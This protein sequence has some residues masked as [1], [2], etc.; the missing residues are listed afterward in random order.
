MSGWTRAF[1]LVA[2]TVVGMGAAGCMNCPKPGAV[3]QKPAPVRA[4][5]PVSIDLS[6]ESDVN[7]VKTQHVFVATVRDANGNPVSGADVEWI[8]SRSGA[9]SVGDIVDV[10]GGKKI[11]NTYA[12]STTG[13]SS[14]TITRGNDNPADDVQVGPGQTW[15]VITSTEEGQSKMVA[16]A[17]SIR[18]WD[19][20]KAFA[21]KNWMDMSWES[22]AD[23]TN[24]VGTPHTFAFRVFKFSDGSPISDV[25]V[26]W[27]IIS[28]PDGT[29]T[30]GGRTAATK[31]DGSGWAKVDLNQ[32]TPM[33]GT[34]EVQI[35]VV[36]P[37][38]KDECRCWP[39]SM[40]G[41]WTVRKTWVA[42]SIA[43]VKNGPA[44]ETVGHSF[45]YD[46][47]VT[48]TSDLEL[49]DVV[50]TDPLNSAIA[51]ESSNPSADVS[52]STLTWRLGSMAGG[53][54]RSI[55]VMVHGTQTGGPYENCAMV[56]AEGGLN[57]RSCV[58]T[59]FAAPA[60]T[61]DKSGP[62][63]A[64]VCD[65]ITYTITVSNTG[66]GEATNVRVVDTMPSGVTTNDQTE[67]NCG[68]I[69]AHE[70]HTFTITARS[71][72]TGSKTNRVTVTGDGGLTAS[73]SVTTNFT[74][75]VLSI[76]KTAPADRKSGR[77]LPY[78]IT[79][80]NVGS[81]DARGVVVTDAIPN[82]ASFTSASD[83]GMCPSGTQVVWNLGTLAPGQSRTVTLQLVATMVQGTIRNTVMAH[84]DC[85]DEVSASAETR[86][87]G[88]AAILLETMD[89]DDP[90][91]IGGTETYV[92]EVTNQG[93]IPDTNV[94]IECTLPPEE[95]FVSAQGPNGT[96][97]TS[98]GKTV[99]FN[100]VP[101][102][103]PKDRITYK[104]V[105]RA[106]GKGD[107]RFATKLTSDQLE[108]SVNETES[109]HIY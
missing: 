18:N 55:Q 39:E 65:P 79:V 19:R 28:G 5:G 77:P 68:T 76:T 10:D 12:V 86:I 80:T 38:G 100:A 26:T 8:L 104:V 47:V 13:S 82:G 62:E 42:P 71:N 90:I 101:S 81:T 66:D 34:N 102:I 23:A 74:K 31:T 94:V 87:T 69:A 70:S 98:S 84:G 21:V 109:T 60:L 17:P 106:T 85:C 48:N 41:T 9:T 14:Y 95:D 72:E 37:A 89:V 61:I 7:P 30:G 35:S 1:A 29:L 64:S 99:K 15:C 43:I 16:Y 96:Q 52:G 78:E 3:E 107:V 27:T 73:D 11:D 51:Y 24:R 54:S 4:T 25:N 57:G 45:A 56:T 63:T 67:W 93:T 108:T 20:H 6:P 105:V 44:R 46:I 58:Q 2:L 92:I 75:C 33:V 50:V 40:L 59:V 36:R 53:S 88:L 22:P 49:R 91:E 83:G 32:S 97:F 103:A